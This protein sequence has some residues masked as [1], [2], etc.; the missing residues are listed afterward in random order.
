MRPVLA[1]VAGYLIM[2]I[3]V[4]VTLTIAWGLLGSSF[5]F[6]SG[7]THVTLRWVGLNL[8]LSV[9]AAIAG[10]YVTMWIAPNDSMLT[11]K[12]LAGIILVVGLIM[13]V[14]HIFTD[15]SVDQHL[16]QGVVVEGMSAFSA[17]SESV[18]PLWYNFLVPIIGA[19]G[20]L[21]GG[22]LRGIEV[23]EG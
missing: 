9:L 13:A 23:E 18:Q 4:M 20:V 16:A 3:F 21:V 2:V 1:V 10:G 17:A 8:S 12:I 22:R 19:V 6:Q 5:A 7:T 14:A 11:V 15:P